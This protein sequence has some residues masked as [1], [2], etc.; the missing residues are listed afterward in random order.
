MLL[1]WARW[2]VCIAYWAVLTVLLLN[3]NPADL[4]HLPKSPLSIGSHFLVFTGLAIVSL[5]T[6]W[7]RMS[8]SPVLFVAAYA[9]LSEYL[10]L[11]FPPRTPEFGDVAENFLGLAMGTLLYWIAYRLIGTRRLP[12]PHGSLKYLVSSNQSDE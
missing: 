1:F 4:V 7:P 9:I 8:M 2:L 6:H 5:A 11:F 3:P 12:P 10:Q